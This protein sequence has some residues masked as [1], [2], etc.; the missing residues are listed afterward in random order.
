M[1]LQSH[2]L[3]ILF[4]VKMGGLKTGKKA[5]LA[6]KTKKNLLCLNSPEFT[7]FYL[8]LYNNYSRLRGTFFLKKNQKKY[9]LSDLFYLF[10]IPSR[11]ILNSGCGGPQPARAFSHD[12]LSGQN[13][14]IRVLARPVHF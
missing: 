13:K 12:R 6:L 4:T 14:K 3:A 9:C 5:V 8:K 11:N 1:S 10:F 2:F 7:C